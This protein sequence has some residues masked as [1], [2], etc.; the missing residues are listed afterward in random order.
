MNES[1]CAPEQFSRLCTGNNTAEDYGDAGRL[2]SFYGNGRWMLSCLN[3]SDSRK[4]AEAMNSS[5]ELL[6]GF[7]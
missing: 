5:D 7:P 2:F 3:A 1:H 4:Q 6:R